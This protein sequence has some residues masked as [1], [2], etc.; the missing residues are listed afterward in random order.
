MLDICRGVFGVQ[1]E[2]PIFR[3]YGTL[4]KCMFITHVKLKL[5]GSQDIYKEEWVSVWSC[6]VFAFFAWPALFEHF[7]FSFCSVSFKVGRVK[8]Q[9]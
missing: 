8:R 3:T 1:N 2:Q 6:M 7:A 4:K 5:Q 9:T